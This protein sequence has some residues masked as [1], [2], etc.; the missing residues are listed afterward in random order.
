GDESNVSLSGTPNFVFATS[1]VGINKTINVSGF[2]LSGPSA[3][4]YD[5][6][7]PTLTA[8]ITAKP[9]TVSGATAN[10]KAYDGT[11][12]AIIVGGTLVGVEAVDAA[13]VSLS[14][15]GSFDTADVG[16]NKPVTV[17]IS[18]SAAFN[19]SLTQPGITA[20]ITKANQTI[21]F[22]EL[23][24]LNVNSSDLNL[25]DYASASSGLALTYQSSNTAVVSV[26]G[27]T[28]TIVGAG[29]AVITASQ[30]GDS[31]YNPAANVT[32]NVT[33]SQ[34]P[35]LIA[36]WDFQTTT[37]GGTALQSAPNTPKQ[38]TANF[39]SGELYLDGT[40]FS[41]DFETAT[42]G[43][44]LN[45]FAGTALN[46]TGTSFS[47][48]T[49]GAASLALVSGTNSTANGKSAVFV[50]N[51]TD[52]T[53]LEISYAVQRTG[54][55]FTSNEWEY[56]LDGT[57]WNPIGTINSI[58]SSFGIV[59]LPVTSSLNNAGI[60]YI[61]LTVT[62][63]TASGSNN[64]LDNIKF[65]ATITPI[66]IP[67]VIWNGTEWSNVD[68]P[69]E[70][71][72]AFIEGAYD[73]FTYGPFTSKNVTIDT[74]GSLVVSSGD[75]VLVY[76]DV[77]NTQSAASLVVQNT[78]NLVQ[79]N[80]VN[81]NTGE[82][83]VEVDSNPLLRLDYT[84]W[85][86]PVVGQNL[87]DFSP[88]TMNNRFYEYNTTT[89]TYSNASINP[90][91]DNF[92]TAKGYLIRMPDT[93]SSSVAS[94]FEGNFVGQGHNGTINVNLENIGVGQRFNAI[95][96]PYPS[97]IDIATFLSVNGPS[98]LGGNDAITGSMWFWR[99]TNNPMNSSYCVY[100][101]ASNV[102]T[103]NGEANAVSNNA[104]FERVLGVGQ[105]FIVEAAGT[106][107]EIQ[108]NN[109]MRIGNTS[110]Q[111]FRNAQTNSVVDENPTYW[112]N[113]TRDNGAFYQMA[114][115][116]NESATT[117]IDIFDSKAF[118]NGSIGLNSI[119]AESEFA[120]QGRPAPF[121]N[122]DIVPL[123]FK[124]N[125]LGNYTISLDNTIGIFND[126]QDIFVEDLLTQVIHNLK[127]SEYSF[128]SEA[129]T[130]NN[131]FRIVYVNE[132][133]GI[134]DN[135]TDNYIVFVQNKNLF[136]DA[137]QREIE[138]VNV[139]D[140]SGRKIVSKTFKNSTRVE[141]NISGLARQAL[142]VQFRT[143]DGSVI[144]KKVI[145]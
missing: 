83:T 54:S 137:G 79:L 76:G 105:G 92:Q 121:N 63:S 8:S 49:T 72:D 118:N 124:A 27:N 61:R 135:Q 123:S 10:D 38:I 71:T 19:Y 22:N 11:T 44:E 65:E 46:T 104:T 82:M 7:Q 85:S 75:N 5:L 67:D 24:P 18:G 113:L 13:N 25:N 84:L 117:G 26:S 94:H 74:G 15:T 47:T 144:S 88:L 23:P 108:F 30:G 122:Q 64:R 45:S 77:I 68:G 78:A 132:T 133:L 1:T 128:I 114:V 98:A 130:F 62:G 36:G 140:L 43:N 109:D 42:S 136:I 35:I 129:G 48:I 66:S 96:N 80:E 6:I 52:Y 4:N 93:W 9:I 31:N 125:E 142:L 115:S 60:A 119:V 143:A 58:P 87:K 120:I 55:G 134:N 89:N 69:D 95:G 41:S 20:N 34:A 59:T 126:G 106:S 3:G 90:V 101:G 112:L 14:S 97:T 39:G 81:N 29:S 16:N 70:N 2:T 12:T 91:T 107:T 28:L 111:F 33:V 110:G 50:L 56:S 116:Y 141:L 99:K 100:N 145:L 40:N 139:F 86:S 32:Q 73:T 17:S 57:V 131:R 37:N 53:D 102:Y 51:M 103:S 138:L 21:T 127:E